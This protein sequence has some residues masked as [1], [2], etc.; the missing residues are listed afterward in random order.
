MPRR[1]RPREGVGSEIPVRSLSR[2]LRTLVCQRSRCRISGLRRDRGGVGGAR[3]K[4][5]IRD[6]KRAGHLRRS[7]VSN[8]GM[9]S[10]MA[11]ITSLNCA[12]GLMQDLDAYSHLPSHRGQF[13]GPAP[14]L[15]ARRALPRGPCGHTSNILRDNT[16]WKCVCDRKKHAG[17]GGV[18]AFP[19]SSLSEQSSKLHQP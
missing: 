1:S 14:C 17:S 15:P 3:K 13:P 11:S 4:E 8:L 19:W 12:T 16:H 2:G 7:S 10:K 9:C 18:T 5:A 6:H